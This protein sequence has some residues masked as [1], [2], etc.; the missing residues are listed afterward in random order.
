MID[1]KDEFI[2]HPLEHM[3]SERV[4]ATMQ[5][6]R[7]IVENSGLD[8]DELPDLQFL[9]EDLANDLENLIPED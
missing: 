9:I 4:K 7:S 2:P 5:Q 8:E 6:I 1:L 3:A